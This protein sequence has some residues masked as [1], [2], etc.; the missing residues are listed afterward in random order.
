MK[1]ITRKISLGILTTALVS[2]PL[3]A[4]SCGK[5]HTL[6]KVSDKRKEFETEFEESIKRNKTIHLKIDEKQFNGKVKTNEEL[7]CHIL[8]PEYFTKKHT[9]VNR[10]IKNK[11]VLPKLVQYNEWSRVKNEEFMKANNGSSP[12]PFILTTQKNIAQ[13]AKLLE[14]L[15]S[16][17]LSIK[18]V[19][20]EGNDKKIKTYKIEDEMMK[21][22]QD[23]LLSTWEVFKIVTSNEVENMIKDVDL[24]NEDSVTDF[25]HKL[26][27]KPLIKEVMKII[28]KRTFL[29]M[30]IHTSLN[31]MVHL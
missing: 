28:K 30:K 4:I 23:I 18:E 13:A 31:S 8:I 16:E 17:L 27:K 5:E 10:I 11:D 6:E 12:K 15:F 21:Y 3:I 7:I 9:F 2:M 25:Y 1:K 29:L 24:S 22:V 14:G 26:I 20:I 19:T